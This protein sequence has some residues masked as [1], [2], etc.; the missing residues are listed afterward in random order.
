MVSRL[1]LRPGANTPPVR[2]EQSSSEDP[3]GT[4][5]HLGSQDLIRVAGFARDNGFRVARFLIADSYLTPLDEDEQ[6]EIS[7]QL[8]TILEQYDADELESAL[9]DDYDGLYIV[10][11]EL[12]SQ[13]TG[14]RIGLRRSGYVS[15]STA[16]LH[17]AELLISEAWRE[18]RLA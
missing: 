1:V 18:L 10:G 5:L 7:A 11:V 17:A 3:T 9:S 8:V 13:G 12:V 15:V 4:S 16:E 2:I 6:R 14:L